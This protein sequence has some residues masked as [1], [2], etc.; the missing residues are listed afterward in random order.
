MLDRVVPVRLYLLDCA[1]LLLLTGATILLA[2]VDLHGW[3]TAVALLIAATKAAIIA[4]F[5]MHL[6]WSP[7]LTRLVGL[8]ALLWLGILIVGTLDD[9]LTRGWL[10]VPGK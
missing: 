3:N 5:F 10:P 6:R 2:H 7:S 4:T 9:V 8:A 1:V